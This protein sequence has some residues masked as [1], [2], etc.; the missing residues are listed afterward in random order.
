MGACFGVDRR[1]FSRWRRAQ[2]DGLKGAGTAAAILL[3]H[4]EAGGKTPRS[5]W[6]IS[7]NE[8]RGKYDVG[9]LLP[10]ELDWIWG[11]EPSGSV[12]GGTWV[13]MPGLD[14]KFPWGIGWIKKR[15]RAL[16]KLKPFEDK[17]MLI[18]RYEAY[19]RNLRN[20]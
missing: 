10:S 2:G 11:R 4:Y 1:S 14:T 7:M 18:E 5:E 9:A 13:M 12:C 16:R 17:K 6:V 15:I 8:N 20:F 19:L 3:E